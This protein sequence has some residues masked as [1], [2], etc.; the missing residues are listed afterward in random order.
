MVHTGVRGPPDSAVNQIACEGSTSVSGHRPEL[1]VTSQVHEYRDGEIPTCGI[2]H[3][4]GVYVAR[5]HVGR[6]A[7][8][9]TCEVSSVVVDAGVTEGLKVAALDAV[10]RGCRVYLYW[11]VPTPHEAYGRHVAEVPTSIRVP[12]TY[13]TVVVRTR[14]P[15]TH[16]ARPVRLT[17]VSTGVVVLVLAGQL[18]S[19]DEAAGPR[20]PRSPGMVTSTATGTQSTWANP[21]PNR[22]PVASP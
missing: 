22:A 15:G 16:D 19:E 4:V 12:R 9:P 20:R 5:S 8:R 18:L 3:P 21:T 1:L 17:H 6:S 11:S 7:R 2:P 10:Q 13:H 14:V